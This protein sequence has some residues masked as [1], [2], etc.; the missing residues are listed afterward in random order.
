MDRRAALK[1]LGSGTLGS[2]L[3]LACGPKGRSF[4][5]DRGG[6]RRFAPVNVSSERVIRIE[7]GLRPYR[8]SGFVVRGARFDEKLV[9]HNYGHGGGG[10][11]LSWGTAHLAAEEARGSH[12]RRCAVI[13]CGAV[14]LAT[15]RLMQRRGWQVTI[16]ARDLPPRTTSNVAGA[17]WSPFSVFEPGRTTEAFDAQFQRAARLAY[18]YF[19]DLV[20]AGYGVRWIDN[21][22]LEDRP[23][24]I[25]SFF[26]DLRD[27]YPDTQELSPDE[28]PFDRP[29]AVHF[30]TMLI[31]PHI[32]LAAVL[33][34]FRLAG[35]RVV[36]REF[37]DRSQL[38]ALDEAVVFNC[39]GLGAHDLFD[40]AELGPRKGQLLVLP[41]QPEVDYILVAD[42]GALYMMPR[43]DGVLLG[44]T[45]ETGV[46][47]LEPNQRAVERVLAGHRRLFEGL[48]PA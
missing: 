5:V 47:N 23:V 17:Q 15:A 24:Q 13:G 4:V 6:P 43:S 28:Y 18:R 10:I 30:K 27:L 31:E 3:G 45:F 32:Y 20:G 33:R 26:D 29:Y 19:Q 42:G 7:V 46:W 2:A 8:P 34:D 1:L 39:T 12:Y 36:V 22:F 35:G 37:S 38:L 25:G 14:G 40:D 21:Y 9:I 11:T 44:G 41:P 16:Y 48:R